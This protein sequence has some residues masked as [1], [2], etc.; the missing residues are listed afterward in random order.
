MKS[1]LTALAMFSLCGVFS[2]NAAP[3]HAQ[4]LSQDIQHGQHRQTAVVERPGSATGAQANMKEMMSRVTSI[5]AKLEEL[6]AKMNA[7]TGEAKTTAI[8]ELLT[9]LVEDRRNT[10]GPMMTNMMWMMNMSSGRSGHGE[11]G[12]S[13][14]PQ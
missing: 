5:D 2:L 12:P 7:A 6:V 13:T 4:Q 10:C 1:R 3:L 8:A 9:A 11:H 14:S